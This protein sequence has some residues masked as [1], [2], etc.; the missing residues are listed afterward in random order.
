MNGNSYFTQR[1][2]ASLLARGHEVHVLA[3]SR[4]MRPEHFQHNGVR[5]HGCGSLPLVSHRPIRFS[6]YPCCVGHITEVVRST[7]PDVIHCQSHLFV[8]RALLEAAKRAGIPSVATNHFMPIN[9][10]VHL[11][12]GDGLRS[13]IEKLAWRDLVSVYGSADVVTAP[14]NVAAEMLGRVGLGKKVLSISC[15]VDVERFR[16]MTVKRRRATV[17]PGCLYVGRL[18]KEKNVHHLIHALSIVRRRVDAELVIVGSGS[19]RYSLERLADSLG[20]KDC[21]VF[22][23]FVPD[24]E[25][26]NIYSCTDVFCNPSGAELLSLAT[27][28][29]MASGK[30]VVA[31]DSAALPEVVRNGVNGLLFTLGDIG[32][33]SEVLTCLLMNPSKCSEMGRQG[34]NIAMLHDNEMCIDAYE[35]LYE[36]LTAV[37]ELRDKVV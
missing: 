9:L 17:K 33:L 21:V 10:T 31:A 8:G 18:E 35:E 6:P 11:P 2:A 19:Q 27:L 14:S 24:S 30:P 13:A 37:S 20:V 26:P 4:R 28:E 34:R 15:G 5:V 23:G 29:A 32:N 7:Q 36:T 22:K 16:P 25:M 12:V 3:P 1:L